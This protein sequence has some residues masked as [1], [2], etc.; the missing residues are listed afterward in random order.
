MESIEKEDEDD[1]DSKN[2]WIGFG[3]HFAEQRYEAM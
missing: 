3:E 2:I 1:D